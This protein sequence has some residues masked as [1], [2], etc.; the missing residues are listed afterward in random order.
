[1]RDDNI[2]INIFVC[3]L[4]TNRKILTVSNLITEINNIY[5]RKGAG[6]CWDKLKNRCGRGWKTAC[7]GGE[8]RKGARG[9]G[10]R[11]WGCWGGGCREGGCM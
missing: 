1:M 2:K 3:N 4:F 5:A 10:N 11:L 7:G 6:G 9:S 8:K